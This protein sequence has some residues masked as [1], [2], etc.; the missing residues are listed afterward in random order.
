M[1]MCKTKCWQVDCFPWIMT[2]L[3]LIFECLPQTQITVNAWKNGVW[4]ISLVSLDSSLFSQH[5]IVPITIWSGHAYGFYVMTLIWRFCHCCF[6]ATSNSILDRAIDS[7]E[8]QHKDF[9]R[10]VR[11]IIILMTLL[12]K[13][14]VND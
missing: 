7:E 2:A 9:L 4:P 8:A 5:C 11:K 14:N 1:V 10:L 13:K 3:I 6:S 12:C